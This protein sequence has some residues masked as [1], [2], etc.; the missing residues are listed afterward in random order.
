[1]VHRPRPGSILPDRRDEPPTPEAFR[2]LARGAE[3]RGDILIYIHGFNTTFDFAV[4]RLAQVVHDIQFSGV[5]V[6][7]SWPSH[8]STW[9]YDADEANALRSVEALAE[10]LLTLVEAQAARPEA[11]A[12]RSMCSPTAWATA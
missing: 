2:D 5:P 6:A 11:A 9:S 4:L 10:T 1:M 7:F 12:A 8:G 3:T